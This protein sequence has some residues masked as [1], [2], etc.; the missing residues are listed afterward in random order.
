MSSYRSVDLTADVSTG[1]VTLDVIDR[2]TKTPEYASGVWHD[3]NTDAPGQALV[4]GCVDG[5][6]IALLGEDGDL[7][8]FSY[9]VLRRVLA[10]TGGTSNRATTL[11]L[12][13]EEMDRADEAAGGP[14]TLGDYLKRVAEY[15]TRFAADNPTV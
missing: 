12:V 9:L 6:A 8:D 4:I 3:G 11:Q 1:E 2:N 10:L 7:E 15:L 14:A 5:A 13:I